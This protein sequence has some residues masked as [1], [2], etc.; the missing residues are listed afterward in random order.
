M[1]FNP[2]DEPKMI[3]GALCIIILISTLTGKRRK[4]PIMGS[5][6]ACGSSHHR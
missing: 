6:L 5:R 1:P 4:L 2:Y 3:R